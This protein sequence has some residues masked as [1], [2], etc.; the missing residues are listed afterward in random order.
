VRYMVVERFIH[1]RPPALFDEW[2]A[3]WKDLAAF[4][5]VPVVGSADA[6]KRLTT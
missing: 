5:I 6:G 3:R 4:E 2:I 1:G